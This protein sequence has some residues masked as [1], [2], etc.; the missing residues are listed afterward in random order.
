MTLLFSSRHTI[1]WA[2]LLFAQGEIVSALEHFEKGVAL[3]DPREHGPLSFVYGGENPGVSCYGHAGWCSALLG[4]PEKALARTRECLRLARKQP[5]PFGQA[6]AFFNAIQVH[7]L[8]GDY[9]SSIESAEEM[10]TIAS[11]QGYTEMISMGTFFRGWALADRGQVEKGMAQMGEGVLDSQITMK[12]FARAV[13]LPF[14][15][16]VYGKAGKAEEGLSMLAEALDIVT[17]TGI[18]MGE[19]EIYRIKGELLLALSAGNHGE[20]EACFD[21]AIE[22]ARRQ[23]AKTL[24][25]RAVTSL[26]RLLQEQGRKEEARTLLSEIYN[27]FTEGFDTADLKKAKVLLESLG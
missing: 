14:Q 4:Y 27:W 11:E 15:A 18:R 7:H 9:E 26:S 12:T 19:S 17:E 10:I 6:F 22:V 1:F 13:W 25:L 20:A 21:R 8:C 2:I 5:H 16:E 3:Y 23:Q 24:E